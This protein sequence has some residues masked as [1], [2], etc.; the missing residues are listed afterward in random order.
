VNTFA[1]GAGTTTASGIRIDGP[2]G[3][4]NNWALNILNGASYFG[5]GVNIGGTTDPGAGCLSVTATFVVGN[6][7]GFDPNV[8][9]NNH[10]GSKSFQ[11]TSG[12]TGTTAALRLN[13]DTTNEFVVQA[14]GTVSCGGGFLMSSWPTTGSA[15]NAVVT[16]GNS[17]SR[18]TSLR[19]YKHDLGPVS[20]ADARRVLN[21]LSP[22]VYRSK[23]AQD[24][25]TVL[26]VGLIAEDVFVAAPML[27]TFQDGV[28]GGVAY[29]RVAMYLLPVVKDH[30]S[31]LAALEARL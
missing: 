9:F 24:D 31:R 8:A 29:E 7:G 23:I 17:L 18:S 2:T 21:A 16:N 11:Y 28:L 26:H 12:A 27:A 22:I 13:A 14:D 15:A 5:G 30:E 20:L 19:E 1:A 4:T 10:D 3:A 6:N 25:P